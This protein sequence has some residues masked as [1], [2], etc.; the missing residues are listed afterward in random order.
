M[1]IERN[2][3]IAWLQR[4]RVTDGPVGDLVADMRS[5]LANGVV[6]P[7][8]HSEREM[9]GYLRGRRACPE[10]LETVPA[11]WRRYRNWLDR[12]ALDWR[13]EENT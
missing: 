5:E 8:F 13:R 12:H 6:I 10:A 9:Y 11:A 1:T 7:C 4:A 2:P 3:T